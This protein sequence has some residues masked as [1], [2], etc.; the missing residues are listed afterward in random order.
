MSF[1]PL[2]FSPYTGIS[3]MHMWPFWWHLAVLSHSALLGHVFLS[4]Y[5]GWEIATY[6]HSSSLILSSVSQ[7]CSLST[8]KEAFLIALT[9]FSCVC[10]GF[11]LDSFLSCW[12]PAKIQPHDLAYC[13]PF[14]LETEAQ[15]LYIPGLMTVA[16]AS[17]LCM[18]LMLVSI[19]CRMNIFLAVFMLHIFCW[20]TD[21]LCK[22]AEPE[23]NRLIHLVLPANG[24]EF[25]S[26]RRRWF[27]AV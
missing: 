7:V 24:H 3:V 23:V 13:P 26:F 15:L 2:S 4:L 8:G 1:V 19:L 20:I 12:F 9:A 17:S 10:L 6:L 11:L 5:F 21:I 14:R 25:P 16:P 22:T 27:E 18:I